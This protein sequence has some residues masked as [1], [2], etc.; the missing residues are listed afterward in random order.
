M[1]GGAEAGREI[2]GTDNGGG[3]T[4]ECDEVSGVDRDGDVTEDAEAIWR[5]VAHTNAREA[6]AILRHAI[7]SFLFRLVNLTWG[8]VVAAAVSA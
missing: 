1:R 8:F 7:G 4:H 6:A 2:G 3:L 5:V